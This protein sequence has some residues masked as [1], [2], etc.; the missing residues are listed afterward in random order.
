[1]ILDIGNYF[2][3]CLFHACLSTP[4]ACGIGEIVPEDI[5]TASEGGRSMTSVTED[6]LPDQQLSGCEIV[7][8]LMGA[9]AV[10]LHEAH[11]CCDSSV[12]TSE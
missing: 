3:V 8:G 7:S 12:C 11:I 4:A 1:M 10:I 2:I 9:I 6:Q 5:R